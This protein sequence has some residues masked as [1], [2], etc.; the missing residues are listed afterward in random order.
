MF[1]EF[2]I[3]VNIDDAALFQ[4][5]KIQ[6]SRG[7]DDV[8]FIFRRYSDFDHLNKQVTAVLQ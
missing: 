3:S 7:P 2:M 6:V 5:F 1:T 8:W 4:V